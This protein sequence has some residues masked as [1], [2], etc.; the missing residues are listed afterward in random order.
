[1]N[2]YNQGDFQTAADIWLRL[3]GNGHGKAQSGLALLY[4]TGS[5]VERDFA[6]ARTLFLKA[7]VQNVPQAQMFLSLMYRRGDGVQQSYLR[8]YMWCD[9]AV[10]SGD[11]AASY[12]RETIAEYLTG[13]EVTEA[14]RLSS[15][16]RDFHLK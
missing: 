12:V 16:W 2:A 1:M 4:Y 15:E 14:Q 11:E 6:R 7:A 9:I 10:G 3:A 5:G 13:A 8:S